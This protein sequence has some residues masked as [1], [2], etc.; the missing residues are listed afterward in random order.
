[1][2]ILICGDR[3]WTDREKIA[4]QL[5]IIA[6]VFDKAFGTDISTR[7]ASEAEVVIIQGCNGYDEDG[8]PSFYSG[9]PT[10]RGADMIARE[11]ALK[12]GFAVADY[13][14]SKEDW[15]NLGRAAGPI[16]NQLQIDDGRPDWSL[17]FHSNI[18]ESKGTKD[19]VRR[20]REAGLPT[21]VI[22]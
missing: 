4:Q 9:K 3:N 2:R 15:Q 6:I 22:K 18:E 10:V 21:E 5:R 17:A 14:V 16:R 12:L 20:S 11:E 13:P 7:D 1:M 19:M 8:K